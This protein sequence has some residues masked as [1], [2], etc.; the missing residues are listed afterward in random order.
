MPRILD[1]SAPSTQK[2]A[3]PT[4]FSRACSSFL[5]I[6]TESQYQASR[7][8][9]LFLANKCQDF[10]GRQDSYALI[11]FENEQILVSRD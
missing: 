3:F 8:L 6:E 4:P 11:Y 7:P 1:S 2:A 5:N 10:I 9:L